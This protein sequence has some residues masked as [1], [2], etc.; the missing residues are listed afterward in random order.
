[1]SSFAYS[2]LFLE[3]LAVFRHRVGADPI[4]QGD[5]QQA[6]AFDADKLGLAGNGTICYSSEVDDS[7]D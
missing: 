6:F 4:D 5:E 7:H 3:A 1:M 2:Q